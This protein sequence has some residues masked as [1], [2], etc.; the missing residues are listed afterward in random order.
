MTY[1]ELQSLPYEKRMQ[2]YDAYDE[3]GNEI[4]KGVIEKLH[5]MNPIDVEAFKTILLEKIDSDEKFHVEHLNDLPE[6]E[7]N[8]RESKYWKST[9]QIEFFFKKHFDLKTFVVGKIIHFGITFRQSDEVSPSVD[10][11]SIL[12]MI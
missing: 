9:K 3:C 12:K 4:M 11:E 5:Q 6:D 7:R 10:I 1:S 8:E 2:I